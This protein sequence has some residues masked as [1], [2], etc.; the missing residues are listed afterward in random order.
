[1]AVFHTKTFIKHDCYMTPESAWINIKEYIP[2]NR[3]IWEPFYG[4]GKSGEYLEKLG[5]NV[6]HNQ[7]DFFKSNEGEIIVSNPPFSQK[8]EVLTRLKQLGKPF[9][10][11]L[12]ASTITTQYVRELFKDDK[13]QI[14][15][16]RRR[17]QFDK[18][19]NGKTPE[20]WKN[21]CYF[22]CLYYCYKME[23]DKDIIWLD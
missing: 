6:I 15:I 10:L 9:I 14:I 20:N 18:K 7:N 5:F 8:K 23:L 1:M 19:I 11:I 16:P 13:L 4:D 2:K 21:A 3:I 17:I 22:D 12:P